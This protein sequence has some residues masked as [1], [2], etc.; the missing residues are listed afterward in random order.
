MGQCQFYRDDGIQQQ[1]SRDVVC[2]VP[3]RQRQALFR[4]YGSRLPTSLAYILSPGGLKN[5][6]LSL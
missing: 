6:N 5:A 2:E 3:R 1:F 4:M